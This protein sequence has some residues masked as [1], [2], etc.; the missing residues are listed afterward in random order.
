[1]DLLCLL[2]SGDLASANGPDG[3][4]GNDNL[5]PVVDLGTDSSKLLLDDGDG[6]ASL[7]LLEGLAAAPNDTNTALGSDLGL[8]GDDL[9]GL[10]EDGAALGVAQNGPGNAAVLK[11]GDADLAGE[12]TVGLVEDVLSGNLE[13]GSELVTDEKEIE[14]RR[15]DYDLCVVLRVS[16]VSEALGRVVMTCRGTKVG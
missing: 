2:N 11:L 15:G 1:M 3:L 6:L 16:I 4:V 14:G 5:A 8:V 12:S 9:V 10:T 7:T 13:A